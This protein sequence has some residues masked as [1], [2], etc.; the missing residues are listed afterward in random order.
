ME[1]LLAQREQHLHDYAQ[2]QTEPGSLDLPDSVLIYLIPPKLMRLAA[3]PEDV[4]VSSLVQARRHLEI[5]IADKA[6]EEPYLSC[7]IEQ[8]P[9]PTIAEV[10][11]YVDSDFIYRKG[12][13]TEFYGRLEKLLKA[14]GYQT[15]T[16]KDDEENVSFYTRK[17][18]R[19]LIHELP[20]DEQIRLLGYPAPNA[21]CTYKNL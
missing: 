21:Y 8:H 7:E 11:D 16:G 3:V 13:T 20:L 10:R 12:I 19:K 1:S 5:I 17:L 18:G 2:H 14:I 9:S 6:L 15:M 4:V